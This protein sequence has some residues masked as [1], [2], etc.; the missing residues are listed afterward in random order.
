MNPTDSGNPGAAPSHLQLRG[1][2]AAGILDALPDGAYVTDTERRVVFWNHAA[3]RITGWTRTDIVGRT[4]YDNLLVHADQDGHQ[5]CGQEFCP[6]HRSIVTDQPSEGS[7]LVFAQAKDGNRVPV[8]VSVAPIHDDSGRVIGGIE[9]F[10]DLSAGFQDLQMAQRIQR[11]ALE[12][13]LPED[14]R[15]DVAV[16]YVPHELVGG[17]F[18]R[19]ERIDAD[20]YAI[21]VADVT[22][23]G[24]S[25]ALYTMQLRAMWEEFRTLLGEP[26]ELLGQMSQRLNLLAAGDSSFA[27]AVHL[28]VDVHSGGVRYANAGHPRP[29]AFTADGEF[30]PLDTHGPGLGLMPEIGYQDGVA[31]LAPGGGLVAFSDGAVEIFDATD[32]M[33]DEEGLIRALK[34]AQ[35]HSEDCSLDRLEKELL[36]FGK[37]VRLPDDLT[38]CVVRRR[39][40]AGGP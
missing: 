35:V 20:R 26:A 27:T 31:Q 24:V 32:Q 25:A 28:V 9:L 11:Y 13:K 14:P 6:L 8:E 16:R 1:L 2:S 18:Y 29:L 10:R 30:T 22:G 5:L 21:M 19:V 40:R 39:P 17:D 15:V 37:S 34:V 38:L 33:L 23:H 7:L 36:R 12:T 3:E 4:C